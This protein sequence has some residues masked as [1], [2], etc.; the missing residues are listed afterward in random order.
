[1]QCPV[2]PAR[3]GPSCRLAAGS[4]MPVGS[5]AATG[6]AHRSRNEESAMFVP[7]P[8]PAIFDTSWTDER[9]ESPPEHLSDRS[10][11]EAGWKRD[12]FGLRCD[13]ATGLREQGLGVRLCGPQSSMTYG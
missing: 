9:R 12:P 13:G 1:V 2:R 7:A 5:R 3:G 10:P 11:R 4:V 6:R 8:L